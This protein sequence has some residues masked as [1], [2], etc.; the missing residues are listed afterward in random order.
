MT[1]S[2]L[3][4][5]PL[6]S[7]AFFGHDATESTINK[8]VR[9]FQKHGSRVVGFMFKR[10][11]PGVQ[12]QAPWQNVD[13]GTTVDRSYLARMPRLALGLWRTLV[14]R[15]A[16]RQCDVIYARNID[17]LLLAVLA[18][19]L[20]HRNATL[21]YEV[22]DIRQ[23]FRGNGIANRLLR[24]AER[25]LM[26]SSSLLV[27]S[28]PDYMP[29][30]FQPLQGYRG[31]WH[32]LENKMT[33]PSDPT[34]PLR[35]G[36]EPPSGPP[37]VIG[38]FGVLKC[39]RSLDL[40]AGLAQALP[41]RVIVHL[42]GTLS[43]FDIPRARLDAVLRTHPNI[44]Y[45]GPYKNPDD[46]EAIYGKLHLVWAADFLD[47][48]NNSRICLPNRLYEGSYFGAVALSNRDTATARRIEQ[49]NLGWTLMEPL[50]ESLPA[51]IRTLT[52]DQYREKRDAVLAAPASHFIDDSDT[53]DLLRRID[54]LVAERTRASHVAH[55]GEQPA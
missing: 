7:I 15:R 4:A 1:A 16:L 47:P 29:A 33:V 36:G 30:Y 11:R 52:P 49:A 46:L 42:R 6:R 3:T 2:Q 32:L 39:A 9:T 37:W 43:E 28:S 44:R 35:R 18:R 48:D 13:L 50:Q 17:M 8:R 53:A 34:I 22:L 12:H 14:H 19:A 40:L 23:V 5:R 38:M 51:F 21:V 41:D 20:V 55:P 54:D 26:A 45:L 24:W 25:R 10:F 27:V 31:P